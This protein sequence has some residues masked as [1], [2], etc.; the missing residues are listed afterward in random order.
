MYTEVYNVKGVMVSQQEHDV[1][2]EWLIGMHAHQLDTFYATR[3]GLKSVP[4]SNV[5]TCHMWKTPERSPTYPYTFI[6]WHVLTKYGTI[7]QSICMHGWHAI[8]VLLLP[9]SLRL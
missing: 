1:S 8:V 2:A 6:Y 9:A 4:T 7:N 3:L 5:Q